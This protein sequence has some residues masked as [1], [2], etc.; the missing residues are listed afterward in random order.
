[1]TNLVTATTVALSFALALAI[2]LALLKTAFT[3]MHRA[4]EARRAELA[5]KQM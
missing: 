2:E 1:M 5:K 4:A 3:L